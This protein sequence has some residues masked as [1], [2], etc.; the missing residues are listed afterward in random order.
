MRCPSCVRVDTKVVDSRAA[1]DGGAI[2]RRRECLD[3]NRRFTTY[4]RVEEAPLVVV[5]RTG[6]R[7]VF[8]RAKLLRGLRAASKNLAISPEQLDSVALEVE[9]A[10]RCEGPDVPS[11]KIGI[12]VLERLRCIDGVAFVRFASVYKGFTD[13]GDFARE[14]L[15]LTSTNPQPVTAG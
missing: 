12:A 13:P 3:C 6:E 7:Q 15:L 9:E 8:D 5:K 4:E 1:E 14:V 10:I 2:R 11:L